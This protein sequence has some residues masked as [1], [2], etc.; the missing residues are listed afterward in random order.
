MTLSI[1][2]SEYCFL[3]VIA[4]KYLLQISVFFVVGLSRNMQRPH[5]GQT[6]QNVTCEEFSTWLAQQDQNDAT[7][8]TYMKENKIFP[9][10]KCKRPGALGTGC[11]FLYCHCKANFCALCG[12]QLKEKQHFSHFQVQKRG[13]TMKVHDIFHDIK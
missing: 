7:F 3:F 13:F 9:C 11:K 4:L 8:A 1:F 10:P 5:K 12:I 2:R 6:D